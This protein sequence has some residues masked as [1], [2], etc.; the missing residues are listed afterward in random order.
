MSQRASPRCPPG[1]RPSGFGSPVFRRF[2]RA[3]LTAG[4]R[5][6]PAADP[7]RTRLCDCGVKCFTWQAE[8]VDRPVRLYDLRCP[9]PPLG[10]AA[11]VGAKKLFLPRILT[12]TARTRSGY[13]TYLERPA[14]CASA[15][16]RTT[17]PPGSGAPA[18]QMPESTQARP[19]FVLIPVQDREGP[20]ALDGTSGIPSAPGGRSGAHDRD[21]RHAGPWLGTAEISAFALLIPL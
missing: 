10:A 19:C 7:L 3:K 6:P 5:P 15:P 16:G 11:R 1:D 12:D 17:A 14:G 20:A 18:F 8:K 13:A 21:R 4:S 2:R 9:W